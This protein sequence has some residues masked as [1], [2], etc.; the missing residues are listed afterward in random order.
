MKTSSHSDNCRWTTIY[1]TA[2]K[3]IELN[4]YIWSEKSSPEGD[5]K[6]EAID[7]LYMTSQ[8]RC[9]WRTN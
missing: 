7:P 6:D 8:R 2:V 9:I 3:A 4:I 5:A 1:C